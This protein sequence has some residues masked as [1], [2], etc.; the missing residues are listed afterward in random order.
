MN[1]LIE[2]MKWNRNVCETPRI[3]QKVRQ[4][5]AIRNHLS[6]Y[7]N[8]YINKMFAFISF[9]FLVFH[10]NFSFPIPH[11]CTKIPSLRV[12]YLSLQIGPWTQAHPVYICFCSI[13]IY[14]K[15]FEIQC[16]VYNGFSGFK[17]TNNQHELQ[18]KQT[19]LIT[20]QITK[21][22][23]VYSTYYI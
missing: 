16:N 10:Q 14:S 9:V 13:Q 15:S 6:N 11:C 18:H 3:C 4:F 20:K 5:L 12:L 2:W 1:E 17:S 7:C 22:I 19:H 23:E 8:C 21:T